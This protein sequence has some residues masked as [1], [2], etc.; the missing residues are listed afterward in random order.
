MVKIF[1]KVNEKENYVN[2]NFSSLLKILI[3]YWIFN[4]LNAF[5]LAILITLGY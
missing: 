1:Y 4:L 5:A 3:I 2:V